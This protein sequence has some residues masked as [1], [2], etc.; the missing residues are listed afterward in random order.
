MPKGA[1]VLNNHA[2]LQNY[3][4]RQRD[5]AV[6]TVLDGLDLKAKVLRPNR[7]SIVTDEHIQRFGVDA[8]VAYVALEYLP[9]ARDSEIQER[10]YY[11]PF[12]L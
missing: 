3:W 11:L 6:A 7:N 12:G 8:E 9:M 5:E 1:Y 4:F 2:T 10:K